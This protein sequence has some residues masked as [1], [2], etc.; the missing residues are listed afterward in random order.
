MSKKEVSLTAIGDSQMSTEDKI[1]K[2]RTELEKLSNKE[3]FLLDSKVPQELKDE[4]C[5]LI[6]QYHEEHPEQ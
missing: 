3:N 2:L 1:K 5:Q 6:M 4:F